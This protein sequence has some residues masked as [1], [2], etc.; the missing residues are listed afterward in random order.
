M[1]RTDESCTGYGRVMSKCKV[2]TV[3]CIADL[4]KSAFIAWNYIRGDIPW[5]LWQLKSAIKEAV[6]VTDIDWAPC[7]VRKYHVTNTFSCSIE[8]TCLAQVGWS[9]V[10][11]VATAGPKTWI[12]LKT[13][14]HACPSFH[15]S[16]RCFVCSKPWS[17]F[18]C[19]DRQKVAVLT[20]MQEKKTRLHFS[21]VCFLNWNTSGTG[22]LQGK[23]RFPSSNIAKVNCRLFS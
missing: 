4:S 6:F 2:S 13:Q 10:T 23:V 19:I 3:S 9:P 16:V 22:H 17:N 14:R 1:L 12:L 15:W 7:F 5:Q 20:H 21:P 8:C 11:V 18:H